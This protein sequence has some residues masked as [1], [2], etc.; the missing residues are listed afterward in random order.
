MKLTIEDQ[1]RE[2]LEQIA[3]YAKENL[4]LIGRI[5]GDE[6]APPEA[7]EETAVAETNPEPAE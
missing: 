4:N 7:K 5:E 3:L 6:A 2:K 1:D